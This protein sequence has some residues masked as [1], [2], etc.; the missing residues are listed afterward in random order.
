[1]KNILTT[2]AVLSFGC[3]LIGQFAAQGVTLFLRE[4]G[5]SSSMLSLLY[6]AMIPFT[7]RFVWA[8]LIDRYRKRHRPRFRVWI[9]G[10]HASVCALLFVLSFTNPSTDAGLVIVIV[11]FIMIALGTELTALGGMVAEGLCE[12][13]YSKGASIQAASAAF[14]GFV[15]GAG[16][17]Y[18]LG[19]LGWQTVI[20][21]LFVMSVLM[22]VAASTYLTFGEVTHTKQ[23]PGLLSQFSIFHRSQ[24][25]RLLAISILLSVSVIVPYAAKSVLLIDA[26]FSVSEGGLIGLVLGNLFGFIGALYARPLIDRMGAFNVLIGIGACNILATFTLV[27]TTLN[28]IDQGSIIGIILWS[29]IAVYATFTANR[30]IVLGLCGKGQEAT[31][32]ASFTSVEAIIFLILAGVSLIFLD[33]IGFSFVLITGALISLL[34][35]ITALFLR[36]RFS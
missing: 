11:A 23:K 7:L 6:I 25:R 9:I 1:M 29:N 33:S 4:A 8:P 15:L 19:S 20:L 5:T 30:S 26:G 22:L 18:L 17:I 14:A 24:V 13:N 2:L 3:G 35:V 16:V 31:D 27:F 12:E 32:L 34:G 10:S 36:E 21:S 28:T